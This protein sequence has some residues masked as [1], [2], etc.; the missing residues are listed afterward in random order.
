MNKTKREARKIPAIIHDSILGLI[1]DPIF[2]SWTF[3][4]ESLR[5]KIYFKMLNSDYFSFVFLWNLADY[6]DNPERLWSALIEQEKQQIS[7][8]ESLIYEAQK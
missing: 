6:C 7:E 4:P 3:L 1:Y 2:T 5:H 8:R